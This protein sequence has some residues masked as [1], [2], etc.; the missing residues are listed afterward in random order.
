MVIRILF[1]S[2]GMLVLLS[3][4][5]SYAAEIKAGMWELKAVTIKG[6]IDDLGRSETVTKECIKKD[7]IAQTSDALL[8][9]SKVMG[10]CEENGKD[11]SK[12]SFT[13]IL[14]SC[15]EKDYEFDI[16]YE[17]RFI[18]RTLIAKFSTTGTFGGQQAQ[19]ISSITGKYIGPCRD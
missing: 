9:I 8:S 4:Q 2:F 11:I 1:L 19:E 18:G 15:K 10:D 13:T 3:L 5:I 12:S 14:F 6:P 17:A 16:A 7:W